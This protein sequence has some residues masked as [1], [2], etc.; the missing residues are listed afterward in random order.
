[1]IHD[2]FTFEAA[3]SPHG[4]FTTGVNVYGW[5]T[6]PAS[7]VLAGQPRKVW[8][9][10]YDTEEEARAAYPDA[11]GSHR[12]LEPRVSLDHLPGE[13]DP[14]PGGMWPDDL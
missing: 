2:Y 4:G 6:Y 13:D 14:V 9:E 8:I 12:L 5:S 7:S 10:H 11:A 3:C 1:M